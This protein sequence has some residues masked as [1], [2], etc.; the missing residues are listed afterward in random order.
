VEMTYLLPTGRELGKQRDSGGSGR[1]GL[2]S[3]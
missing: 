3:S 1:F 2:R